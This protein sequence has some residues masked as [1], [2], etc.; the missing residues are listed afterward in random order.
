LKP[1]FIG[2]AL[3]A[4]AIVLVAGVVVRIFF[5]RKPAPE[6]VERLRRLQIHEK[7]KLGDAEIID[8]DPAT[9]SITYSYSVAGV[10]YTAVQ[11]ATTMQAMLPSEPMSMIG[12]VAIKFIPNN[13][14]N[15]IILCEDWSGLRQ[16][17]RTA[18][19]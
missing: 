7:G 10:G 11:D 13:P 9:W 15:S 16:I 18:L 17:G 4:L 12:P 1:E 2:I 14:A 5:A 3:S 6:E 19:K 8:V